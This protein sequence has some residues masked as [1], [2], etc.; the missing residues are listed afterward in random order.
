M[1]SASH[2]TFEMAV[3]ITCECGQHLESTILGKEFNQR[4]L[5]FVVMTRPCKNCA[6]VNHAVGFRDHAA[7]EMPREEYRP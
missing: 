5:E 3:K 4:G 1:K 6:S 7:G 2:T